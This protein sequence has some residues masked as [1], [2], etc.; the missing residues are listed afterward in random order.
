MDIMEFRGKT[1][2]FMTVKTTEFFQI[3]YRIPFFQSV[4]CIHESLYNWI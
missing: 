1:F 2:D 4:L 3:L